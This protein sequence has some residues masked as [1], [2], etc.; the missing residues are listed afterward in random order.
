MAL[1]MN[2]KLVI[3]PWTDNEG[4]VGEEGGLNLSNNCFDRQ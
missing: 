3:N 1:K 4:G 2:L